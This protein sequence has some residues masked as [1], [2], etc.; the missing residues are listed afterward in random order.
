MFLDEPTT[1]QDSATALGVVGLLKNL[2]RGGTGMPKKTVVMVIHQPRAE[3]F[4][5]IDHIVLVAKGCVVYNGPR[6]EAKEH[7]I[8]DAS[9]ITSANVMGKKL[10][11]HTGNLADELMDIVVGMK[12]ME[13]KKSSALVSS[14]PPLSSPSEVS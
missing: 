12:P 8:A 2:A 11:H 5:M 9:G 10:H 4:N 6:L 13:I 7:L 3:I 14:F 1:G